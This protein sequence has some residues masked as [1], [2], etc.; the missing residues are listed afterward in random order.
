M[1]GPERYRQVR[2]KSRLQIATEHGYICSISNVDLCTADR[3][4]VKLVFVRQWHIRL[5]ARLTRFR[6]VTCPKASV[7][8]VTQ[9]KSSEIYYT[10][11]AGIRL[12]GR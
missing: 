6:E 2:R 4:P 7:A 11:K 5:G 10:Y 8:L 3:I 1:T 12:T 9:E